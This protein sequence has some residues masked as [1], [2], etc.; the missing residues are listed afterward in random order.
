[1]TKTD[2][3]RTLLLHAK[4]IQS[5]AT[6]QRTL[7]R[8]NDL[9]LDT[10]ALAEQSKHLAIELEN[11]ELV[12]TNANL[13]QIMGLPIKGIPEEHIGSYL[14]GQSQKAT[15]VANEIELKRRSKIHDRIISTVRFARN[16]IKW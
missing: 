8:D 10:L 6:M 14:E 4:V 11:Y 9:V 1:M 5:F 15:E 3:R 16:Q 12:A 2:L 7:N 13:P